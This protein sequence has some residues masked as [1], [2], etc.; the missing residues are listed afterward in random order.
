MKMVLHILWISL[1]GFQVMASNGNV[2]EAKIEQYIELSGIDE[3]IDSMPVQINAMTNQRLL[4]SEN[5]EVDKEVMQVLVDAWD[6]SAI[7]SSIANYIQDNSND[8][9]V[10]ELIKWRKTPLIVKIT[11]AEA[12]TS[13][14]NFQNGLLRYIADLQVAPPAPETVESI[15]RLV[16][17]TDMTEMM[18]EMIV[19][20][21]KAMTAPLIDSESQAVAILDKEIDSMRLLLTPQMEQQ[22]IL[23][24]Y[25]I[26]RNI[27]DEELNIYSSFYETPIGKRELSIIFESLN[28]A[29]TLWAEKSAKAIFSQER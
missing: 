6:P 14:P 27:S 24:S 3:M 16:V 12:E 11:D 7:K 23:M 8:A 1:L 18:V 19:Q 9:D 22:A 13:D 28:V 15:R 21:T 25:Y 4:T 29:M 26:Y 5:P 20:I 17:S 10:S 2:A